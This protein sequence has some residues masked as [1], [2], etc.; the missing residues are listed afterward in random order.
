MRHHRLIGLVVLGSTPLLIPTMAQ[1]APEKTTSFDDARL[2]IEFNATDGD[3]GFQI[4][5]DAE[6][7]KQFEIFR[8]DGRR[9]VNFQTDGNLDDFGLTE[10]FSESS[11]PPFTELPFAEFKKLFPAGN[12]RFE[13]VTID[14]RELESAVKFSHQILDAPQ[15]IQ[16]QDGGTLPANN[17]VIRW[18]PV[19]GAVDYEV[20]VTRQDDDRAL[21][22]TLSPDHTSLTVPREFIDPGVSYQIEV[23]ASAAS[24]NRIF[25]QVSFSAT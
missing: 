15:F 16:P 19:K 25:S 13:G 12:Y 3:A 22:V 17:P 21:D 14:G 8:P 24:G 5:A 9:I 20:I 18:A 4:F 23:H 2:E 7:W 10:L 1:G 6:E 11:E